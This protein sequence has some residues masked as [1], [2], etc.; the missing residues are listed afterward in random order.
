MLGKISLRAYLYGMVLA[1]GLPLVA[2]LIYTIIEVNSDRSLEANQQVVSLASVVAVR[3]A[4]LIDDVRTILLD[5]SKTESGTEKNR[6]ECQSDLSLL[7]RTHPI[8]SDIV[9]ISSDGQELCSAHAPNNT[10]AAGSAFESGGGDLNNVQLGTA[11]QLSD[12]RWVT[13]F[14]RPVMRNGVGTDS[15]IIVMIDL[16]RYLDELQRLKRPSDL[17]FMLIDRHGRVLFRSTRAHHWFGRSVLSIRAVRQALKGRSATSIETGSE[18]RRLIYASTPIGATGWVS[19]VSR[20]AAAVKAPRRRVL[21]WNILLAAVVVIGVAVLAHLLGK[22]I[23]LPLGVLALAAQSAAGGELTKVPTEGASREVVKLARSFNDMVSARRSAEDKLVYMASYDQLTGLANRALFRER[24]A[25]AIARARRQEKLVALLFLDLDGFKTVNDTLGHQVGDQLLRAVANRLSREI[26]ETDTLARLGGDEFTVIMENVHHVED[27]A[28]VAEKLL[29]VL[30]K[31]FEIGERTLHTSASVGVVVFPLNEANLDDL[32][33][34][35]DAAMYKAKA[36]GR[37]TYRFFT[38]DLDARA[39]RRLDLETQLRH[40]LERNE[41]ELHYQPQMALKTGEIIGVEALL[42]WNHPDW[43][44]VMPS[45]FIPVLEETGMIVQAGHWVVEQAILQAGACRANGCGG[46]R[47]A[48]N[49]S[50]RQFRDR[51]L[52]DK[53]AELLARNTALVDCLELEL[54]E[55]ILM[56]DIDEAIATMHGLKKLGVRLSV[57]DF[58]TGYSSLNYLKRFPLDTLKIDQSF[59]RDIAIDQNSSTIVETVILLAHKLGFGVVAE[60]VQTLEQVEFLRAHKCDAV[61]GYWLSK[62][63]PAG[64]LLKWLGEKVA[65]YSRV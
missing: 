42:R 37:N 26:R 20:P 64:E 58:G 28:S 21:E 63:Q 59:V 61:Q 34:H 18:G 22:R 35:A 4:S 48:V 10:A 50:A 14:R 17:A 23:S 57:D 44:V 45:E 11:V 15:A 52:V 7:T 55:S 38:A 43:G 39:R 32:I 51:H 24:L 56:E 62:P 36:S 40:A 1:V 54:T 13:Y 31:P 53:V 12:G 65:S 60:G 41:F 29:S 5:L 25:A 8:V 49:L 9:F 27:I 16:R 46:V 33:A 19:T 3:A 30:S 2:T 47:I 6:G